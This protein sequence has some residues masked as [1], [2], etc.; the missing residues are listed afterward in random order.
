MRARF[1]LLAAV[2]WHLSR[3]LT[4][5]NHVRH[6]PRWSVCVCVCTPER[7]GERERES[8]LF[9]TLLMKEAR[10]RKNNFQ[11]PLSARGAALCGRE[12]TRAFSCLPFSDR[13]PNALC[14]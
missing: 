11:N 7:V 8:S 10:G 5:V 1:L 6:V 14:M 9:S 12:E 13:E 2:M 4:E 3:R